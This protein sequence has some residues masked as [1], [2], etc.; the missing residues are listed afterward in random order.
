MVDAA[1]FPLGSLFTIALAVLA[2]VG[3]FFQAKPSVPAPD[4]GDPLTA[5]SAAGALSPTLVTV[6]GKICPVANVIFPSL[7]N[8]NPVSLIGFAPPPYSRFSDPEVTLVL[9]P[10]GSAC[11]RK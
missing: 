8:R 3:A 6:P 2:L 7:P 1:K 5:K 9:L 11:S 4:T 10:S